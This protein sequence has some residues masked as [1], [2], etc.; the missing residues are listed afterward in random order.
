MQEVPSCIGGAYFLEGS[1][2]SWVE[3][4]EYDSPRSIISHGRS[5]AAKRVCGWK[6]CMNRCHL[7]YLYTIV[8]PA[9]QFFSGKQGA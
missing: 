7:S 6:A 1:H 9:D 4:A 2:T 3:P 5:C 8:K